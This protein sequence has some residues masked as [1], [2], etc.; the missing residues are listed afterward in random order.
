MLYKSL[1]AAALVGHSFVHG[2][3]HPNDGDKD[4]NEKLRFK[5]V[6][7]FSI[8]GMHS[9]DIEKWTKHAPSGAIA[10]LF[11]TSYWYSHALCSAPSDS[12]P[13]LLNLITGGMSRSL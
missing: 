8:D 11:K 6:A 5:H 4:H 7:L 9:S 3:P 12:F 10:S 13:G 2:L 1:L